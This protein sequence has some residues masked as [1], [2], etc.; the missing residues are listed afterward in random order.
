MQSFLDNVPLGRAQASSFVKDGTHSSSLMLL[1]ML[2]VGHG[3]CACPCHGLFNN[4]ELQNFLRGLLWRFKDLWTLLVWP[5]E[6]SQ[7]ELL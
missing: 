7:V 5:S 6:M 2:F 1:K 3:L 4:R